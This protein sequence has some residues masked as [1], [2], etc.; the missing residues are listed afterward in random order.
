MA[1][2]D[3]KEVTSKDGTK[4]IVRQAEKGDAESL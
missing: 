3:P 4:G 1:R 2:I